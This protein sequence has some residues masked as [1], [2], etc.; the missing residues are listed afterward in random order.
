[1]IFLGR[2]H[3]LHRFIRHVHGAILIAA[4]VF[5][6]EEVVLLLNDADHREG[7]VVDEYLFVE[8]LQVREELIGDV[9]ADHADIRAMLV[10]GF[11]EVASFGDVHRRHSLVVGGRALHLSDV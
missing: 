4:V 9:R 10:L 6:D 3:L 11:G 5:A 7:L 8:R 1:M 2:V